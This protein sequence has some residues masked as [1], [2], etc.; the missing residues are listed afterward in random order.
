MSTDVYQFAHR[1]GVA[2]LRLAEEYM[3]ALYDGEDAEPDDVELAGPYDGC[4]DCIV[5]EI[6][7]AVRPF[8]A[9]LA[10]AEGQIKP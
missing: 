6:L 3:D 10:I 4:E 5:R 9:Q 8:F 1:A 7:D 2:R